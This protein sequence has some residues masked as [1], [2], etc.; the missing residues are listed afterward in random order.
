MRFCEKDGCNQPVFSTCK[1]SRKG[2][3]RSHQYL[4][5]SFDRRSITQRGI[6]KH[7]EEQ[8]KRPKGWFNEEFI[9]DQAGFEAAAEEQESDIWLWFKR[10]RKYMKG[11]CEHCGGKT[12]RDNDK[13]FHFSIAHLLEKS[14]FKSVATHPENWIELC[15]Y[16]NSCHTNFDNKMINLIDLN[17]FDSVIDK[18][19]KIYPHIAAD[20][21]RRIPP[22]LIEYMKNEI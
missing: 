2:Y 4:K 5:E 6:D 9:A 7:K 17:C 1:I 21:K 14:K 10:Q 11:V 16:G 12:E 13:T 3:C 22:I 8:K 20:E 15:Y 19:V 18:F